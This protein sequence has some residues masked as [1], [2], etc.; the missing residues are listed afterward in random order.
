MYRFRPFEI[1]DAAAVLGF[2]PDATA[3][4]MTVES[5]G[6]VAGY[7]GVHLYEGR[8][9][10]FFHLSDEGLRRPMFLHRLVARSLKVVLAST[11]ITTIYA[12]CNEDRSRAREWLACLGFRPLT[13]TEKDKAILDL[14]QQSHSSAWVSIS[15]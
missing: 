7:G 10:V 1:A 4:G 9:W 8:H 6:K 15:A 12:L 5:D 14:E 13:D 2:E 11:G 3:I